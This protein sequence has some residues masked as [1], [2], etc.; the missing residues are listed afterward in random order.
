MSVG[1]RLLNSYDELT[2]SERKVADYIWNHFDAI[3]GMSSRDLAEKT[4]VSLGT[5]INFC[6]AI[7]LDGYSSLR[8]ALAGD[9]ARNRTLD[10]SMTAMDPYFRQLVETVIA[11]D[12]CLDPEAL[13]EASK[14][15]AE[16]SSIV[17]F[18][19]GSSG[20]VCSM[21]A[22]MLAQ[23]GRLIYTFDRLPTLHA[24]AQSVTKGT[25]VIV[26]SHRGEEPNV[27]ETLKLCKEK[28]GRTIAI[29]N[30]NTNPLAKECEIILRTAV[31]TIGTDYVTDMIFQPVRE[32]QIAVVRLLVLKA[33]EDKIT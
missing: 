13:D 8:I 12:E 31:K 18:G 22:E 14:I 16:A 11:T 15:M 5:V 3:P 20:L 6:K 21:A 9:A 25:A 26:V 2:P 1:Q 19:G 7:G 4:G 10:K 27:V 33:M 29:T 24:A 17:M 30:S 28:G 32:A 23:F